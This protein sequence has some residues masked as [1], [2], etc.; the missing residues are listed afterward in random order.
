MDQQTKVF[1]IGFQKTATTSL[2][3]ALTIL[4]YNVTGAF[5]THDRNVA[6]KVYDDAYDL[7]DRFDAVQ[8]T[9]WPVLYK[10]LDRWHPGSKFILTIRPT[11]KWIKSVVTHFK[12]QYIPLHEWIYGVR[13]AAGHEDV[14]VRRYE[15][16]NREVLEYFKDRPNDLLVM[17]I[18]KGDGWEK[19]CPFLGI[20]IP[21]V[22]F[23]SQ[24]LAKEREK[25]PIERGVRFL[26]RKL[27]R[28]H[29][30]RLIDPLRQ[31]VSSNF[32]RDLFHYHY[33]MFA[34][35]WEASGPLSEEQFAQESFGPGSSI[36]EQFI[37]QIAE[38]QAWLQR[39][40]GAAPDGADLAAASKEAVYAQWDST[41][42][43]MREYLAHLSAADC[44]SRL[45]DGNEYVWE[46]LIHLTDL[47]AQQRS[48]IRQSLRSLGV[49]VEEQTLITFFRKKR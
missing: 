32:V 29:T 45:S 5:L 15:Q 12:E 37:R 4:G 9:P 10:E 43:A 3:A 47:G 14:Y 11:E 8:D 48:Y 16:H 7:A 38:E 23:P 26:V 34:R 24:N 30:M 36:R 13:H 28:G 2:A 19:L 39:L 27:D 25:R 1:G 18:T 35:L 21:P 22:I 46:A 49:Q 41:R 42:F 33:A 44:N 20:G 17:D 31:G 40:R 6:A